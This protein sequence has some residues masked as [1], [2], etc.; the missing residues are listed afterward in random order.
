MFP[1]TSMI[2]IMIPERNWARSEARKSSSFSAAK[3]SRT[4]AVRP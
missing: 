3:A 4:E 1:M 2:G